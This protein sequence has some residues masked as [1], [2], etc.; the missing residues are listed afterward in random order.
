M[1]CSRIRVRISYEDFFFLVL[2]CFCAC[3]FGMELVGFMCNSMT[4]SFSIWTTCLDLFNGFW[5]DLGRGFQG[6]RVCE[7]RMFVIH[8]DF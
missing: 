6:I 1:F 7:E 4:V 3:V 2:F 8:R 5:G